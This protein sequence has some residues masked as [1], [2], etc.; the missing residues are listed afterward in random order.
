MRAV[1]GSQPRSTAR[2]HDGTTRR[3][4]PHSVMHHATLLLALTV[5]TGCAG[6]PARAQACSGF[7]WNPPDT[8][9]SADG[10]V[11]YVQS[12]AVVR[13]GDELLMFGG[14]A[15]QQ[16]SGIMH[17]FAG[18][19]VTW[20]GGRKL[21]PAAMIPMPMEHTVLA[22]PRAVTTADGVAVAWRKDDVTAPVS[23]ADTVFTAVLRADGWTAPAMLFPDPR[24]GG[25]LWW[26]S[27]TVSSV[28][29]L[30]GTR[31]VLAYHGL[32][33][34]LA[35]LSADPERGWIAREGSRV[36]AL[37]PQLATSTRPPG[38]TVL[39]Y[40]EGARR[41]MRNTQFVVRSTDAGATWSEPEQLSPDAAGR[42]DHS[43]L[44]ARADGGFVL[45]W[46]EH[47]MGDTR[48]VR[49][50][51][52]DSTGSGWTLVAGV[53][54][55]ER[56]R[57]GAALDAADRLHVVISGD[58]AA[59]GVHLVARDG[60]V[61]TNALPVLDGVIVPAPVVTHLAADTM[62]ATWSVVQDPRGG[63]S[64]PVTVYSVGHDACSPTRDQG[65][66]MP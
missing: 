54:V 23:R 3:P 65:A 56:E 20:P 51:R 61:A 60:E 41:P 38:T 39:A 9:R 33:K 58:A 21:G 55:G 11:M 1:P 4:V 59:E 45:L 48:L 37:Y 52:A 8:L 44:F 6:A 43:R 10:A 29:D 49:I 50:A 5:L 57:L 64:F 27:G 40:V 42:A 63:R 26:R 17:P 66:P 53:P 15:W 30:A 35:V 36:S 28:G 32:G 7:H 34:P 47:L 13:R 14:P 22:E 18:A 24:R 62:L 16:A 25:A 46:T 19:R 12:P 2:A 31:T